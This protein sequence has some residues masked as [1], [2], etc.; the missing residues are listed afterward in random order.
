MASPIGHGLMGFG[1]GR[2]AEGYGGP[3]GPLFLATCMVFAIAPDLDF[4][5][6]IAS[7]QPALHHQ[8]ASHSIF[9]GLS[10]SAIARTFPS[11]RCGRCSSTAVSG[12]CA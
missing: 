8:G 1:I 6:G 12:R 10:L 7:G 4:L 9:V 3:G 11:T 5:P 2:I